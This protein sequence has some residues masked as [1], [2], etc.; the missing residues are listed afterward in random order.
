MFAAM[1]PFVAAPPP[2]ATPG[3]RWGAP[4]HVR[5]LFGDRISNLR[6]ERQLLSVT[7]FASGAEFRDYFAAHY[8][9]TIAAYRNIADEPDQTAALDQVLVDLANDHGVTSGHLD[10]EYLLSVAEVARY[11]T[12]DKANRAA[13]RRP[14]HRR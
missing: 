3:P 4:E 7:N 13:H 2:G 1:K 6:T 12:S 9:P 5:A 8:G 10:W 14:D 11:S